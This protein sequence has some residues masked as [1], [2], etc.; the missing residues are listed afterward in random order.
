V[1]KINKAE[2]KVTVKW[3]EEKQNLNWVCDY[4]T[5]NLK[6]WSEYFTTETPD[7]YQNVRNRIYEEIKHTFLDKMPVATTF[8]PASRAA[9]AVVGRNSTFV[10]EYLKEFVTNKEFLLAHQNVKLNNTYSKLLHVKEIRK[11]QEGDDVIL[12]HDDGRIVPNLFA[13]S[14]QQELVYLLLLMQALPTLRFTYG[15]MT[16]MFIEEPSAHLFPVEQKKL[17]ENIITLFRSDK[18]LET[19]FFI[20]THSPYI[21]NTINNML[22]K[23]R[24]LKDAD[25]KQKEEIETMLPFP[26]L[27]VDEIAAYFIKSHGIVRPIISGKEG[28]EYLFSEEIE[29]IT[30]SIMN[31]IN[32]IEELSYKYKKG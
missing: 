2:F 19:R 31:D 28:D 7:I 9:L 22:G 18:V 21:L 11:N 4:L 5:Q 12:E 32:I 8:I 13:S 29:E 25:R 23:G 17:L 24:L 16:S 10:D 14:G 1:L 6:K 3:D 30:R 26:H 20:T 15:K 27:D